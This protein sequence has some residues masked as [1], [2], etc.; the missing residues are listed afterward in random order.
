MQA[1]LDILLITFNHIKLWLY[2]F[3]NF[4][5]LQIYLSSSEARL[6]L[7]ANLFQY[8]DT[9]YAAGPR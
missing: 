6:Y 9:W 5:I 7:T 3:L 2:T 1:E 4:V 8:L